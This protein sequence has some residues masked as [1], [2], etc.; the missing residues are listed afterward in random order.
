MVNESW[1]K[2]TEHH[3]RGVFTKEASVL[4]PRNRCFCIL[5]LYP[6]RRTNIYI[7]DAHICMSGIFREKSDLDLN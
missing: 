3:K 6:D 7:I 5:H 2:E 1:K 4:Q